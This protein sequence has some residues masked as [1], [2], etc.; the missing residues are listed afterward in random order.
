VASSSLDEV[1][2][3]TYPEAAVAWLVGTDQ[4]SVLEIGAGDGA[5]TSQ[6]LALGHDVHA[7]DSSAEAV[8]RLAERFAGVRTSAATAERLPNIDASVD[9]VVCRNFAA[10]DEDVALVEFS[11]VLRPGG[12]V[13]VVGESLDVKIPWV[14][15]FARLLGAGNIVP[16]VPESIVRS[17]SFGFVDQDSFRHWSTVDREGLCAIALT[18]PR[19]AT[20]D[21]A[22][23]ERLLDDVRALYD[24]YG[25]GHDGM[26][27]P[28][29]AHCFRAGVIEHPWSVPPR[30]GADATTAGTPGAGTPDEDDD[31]LLIDFR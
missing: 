14:R 9:V 3:T 6:L 23:Q 19:V 2:E 24:D 5:L 16:E 11:R 1:S 26:Q 17:T 13:A 25:R 27:L 8:E 31:G 20:M 10:Y 21:P 22:A 18:D 28:Q 4:R 12:H 7:T 30:E 29:I 15:K